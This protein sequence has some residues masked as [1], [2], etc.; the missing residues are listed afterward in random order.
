MQPGPAKL[1]R[2]LDDSTIAYIFDMGAPFEGFRQVAALLSGLLVLIA[3]GG[4]TAGSQYPVLAVAS[5]RYQAAI[6]KVRSA[7]VPTQALHH[8]HH[9]L[10]AG[11]LL[12]SALTRSL[13]T[14]GSAMDVNAILAPLERGWTQLRFASRALPG[15]EVVAFDRACC[16]EH[17]GTVG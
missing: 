4:R 3:A 14:Q 9:L 1:A 13:A 8:H 16:A 5:D 15:F 2:Q 6:D 7:K 10:A 12:G 17:G 11:L